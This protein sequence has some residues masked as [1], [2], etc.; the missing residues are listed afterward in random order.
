MAPWSGAA[1][2]FSGLQPPKPATRNANQLV[3]SNLES[4]CTFAIRTIGCPD[5]PRRQERC[6]L[7]ECPFTQSQN[8]DLRSTGTVNRGRLLGK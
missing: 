4:A 2:W 7:R 3:L 5:R 1:S 6:Q 8:Q